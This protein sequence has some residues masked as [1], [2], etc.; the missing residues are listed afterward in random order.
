MPK[1]ADEPHIPDGVVNYNVEL[2]KRGSLEKANL[3]ESIQLKVYHMAGAPSRGR[4]HLYKSRLMD[5]YSA[6]VLLYLETLA[7]TGQLPSEQD[8]M[9][10][11]E[12]DYHNKM[13]APNSVGTMQTTHFKRMITKL[14]GEIEGVTRDELITHLYE[15][16]NTKKK[17]LINSGVTVNPDGTKTFNKVETDVELTPDEKLRI[18]DKIAEIRGFTGGP[19]GFRMPGDISEGKITFEFKKNPPPGTLPEEYKKV[20]AAV[21]VKNAGQ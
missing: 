9:R 15:M 4:V 11:I 7:K 14:D 20:A 12:D 13:F 18:I 2:L 10:E 17:W 16:L 1:K 3:P 5:R 8:I 21:E 6:S 19:G